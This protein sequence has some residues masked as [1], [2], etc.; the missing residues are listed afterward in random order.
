MH[1]VAAGKRNISE[2]SNCLS[3]TGD[4][5]YFAAMNSAEM[6]SEI[7]FVS[8]S[9]LEQTSLWSILIFV[10]VSICG[11]LAACGGRAA[12]CDGS[13]AYDWSGA[14]AG[15]KVKDPLQSSLVSCDR[16]TD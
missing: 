2:Q 14:A 16:E 10:A 9:A 13:D 3:D 5:L 4:C 6:T 11:F 12:S 7:S 15:R 1:G 8:D